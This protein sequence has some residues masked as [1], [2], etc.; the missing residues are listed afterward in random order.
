MSRDFVKRITS[1]YLIFAVL[2]LI[3]WIHSLYYEKQEVNYFFIVASL[4]FLPA[5]FFIKDR[6]VKVISLLFLVFAST[7]TTFSLIFPV[8]DSYTSTIVFFG[9]ISCV[10][11]VYIFARKSARLAGGPQGPESR[12]GGDEATG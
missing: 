6:F 8:T 10:T 3:A 1:F 5:F 9:N 11:A 2:S 4:S 7:S 12:G